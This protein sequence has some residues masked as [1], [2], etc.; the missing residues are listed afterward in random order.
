M[1]ETSIK[2]SGVAKLPGIQ[3]ALRSIREGKDEIIEVYADGKT[4][5]LNTHLHRTLA[6]G[7]VKDHEA[8]FLADLHAPLKPA[9]TGGDWLVLNEHRKAVAEVRDHSELTPE[10][11]LLIVQGIY[12]TQRKRYGLTIYTQTPD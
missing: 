1:K 8:E 4:I 12:K 7:E 11:N 6:V 2:V 5:I 9:V 3:T 10:Q